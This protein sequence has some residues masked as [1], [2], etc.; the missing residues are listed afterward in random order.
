MIRAVLSLGLIALIL[1]FADA[2]PPQAPPVDTDPF[3]GAS[4]LPKGE[5]CKCS[6]KKGEC[7]CCKGCCCGG[8]VK[9]NAKKAPKKKKAV[10]YYQ[11]R[12]MAGCVGGG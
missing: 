2:R 6:C 10:Y 5:A 1:T 12:M 7:R 8:G 3:E 4:K 9:H 11:P